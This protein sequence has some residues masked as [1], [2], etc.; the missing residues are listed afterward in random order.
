[1]IVLKVSR[2][3]LSR[4]AACNSRHRSEE[5]QRAI[6]GLNG[7]V[8]DADNFALHKGLREALVSSKVQVCVENL[9]FAKERVFFRKRLFHFDDHVGLVENFFRC[10]EDRR[11]CFAIVVVRN[12]G[13]DACIVLDE[14]F[15]AGM[16]Q[17]ANARNH[18][19]DAVLFILNFLWYADDH[20][21]V[22]G[23]RL[24]FKREFSVR[25]KRGRPLSASYWES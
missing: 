22:S 6:S 16:G 8:S 18:H 23:A 15:V 24:L 10:L 4:H 13:T 7:F 2:A 12:A 1:M 5:W 21:Q 11:A 17:S 9:T 25:R 14:N 3:D 19:T 20:G